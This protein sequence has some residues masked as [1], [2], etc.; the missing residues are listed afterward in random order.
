MKLKIEWIET[1]SPDWKVATLKD[2]DGLPYDDASINRTDKKGRVFPNFDNL[3]AG[4]EIEGNPWK[5]PTSGK[6]AI[7]PP[8]EQK[9]ATT[10]KFGRSGGMAMMKE[11]AKNIEEAQERKAESI[12]FFNATN[13]AIALVSKYQLGEMTESEIRVK[14]VAWRDW[15]L[16]EFNNWNK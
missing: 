14:I 13:S 4:Q 2:S 3:M 5:N 10:G 6:W 7:Y 12:A 16:T 11:K 15:F 1:K 8:D 9:D